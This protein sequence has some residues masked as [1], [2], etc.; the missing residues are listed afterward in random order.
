KRGRI[1]TYD[2]PVGEVTVGDITLDA[3]DEPSL[4][5]GLVDTVAELDP[6][7]IYTTGGDSFVMPY[8]YHR[9]EINLINDKFQLGREHD[10]V[11]SDYIPSSE[12][13][14][15]NARDSEPKTRH[16]RRKGKSYFTYGQIRYKPPF[17]ALKGRIHLDK[18][19]SFIFLESGLYGLIELARLAWIPLQTM[20]RLSP[21]T[22]ISGMQ[23]NQ[24]LRDGVLVRWKKNVPESFKNAKTLLLAD[25][26]G[27]IF[28]PLVG[29]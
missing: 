11:Y 15:T 10:Q 23:V 2:D 17:Y 26:G 13:T 9:A 19:S 29:A 20:S 24:A 12:Q 27:H 14:R 4:L 1:V 18:V 25:R 28:D 3:E 5:M 16:P 21:G 7:I 8:L 6:D 22:A